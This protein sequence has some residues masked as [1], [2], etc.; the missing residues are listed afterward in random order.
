LIAF[1]LLIKAEIAEQWSDGQSLHKPVDFIPWF[2]WLFGPFVL[3]SALRDHKCERMGFFLFGRSI[4][5][6]A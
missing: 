5:S 1:F 4:E 3:I 2:A 6:D